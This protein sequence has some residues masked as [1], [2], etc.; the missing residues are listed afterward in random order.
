MQEPAPEHRSRIIVRLVQAVQRTARE[1]ALTIFPAVVISLL[2]NVYVAGATIVDGPSMQPNLYTDYRVMTERV[3]YHLHPPRRG[4]V[5]VVERPDGEIPLVKRVLA[6]PGEIVEVRGGH[7][8]INHTPIREPW[9]TYW[10]GQDYPPTVVPVGHVFVLGDN[11]AVS[12]DSREIGPVPLDEVQRHVV[13]IF[14]P[15]DQI[16]LLP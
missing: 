4:D 15:L 11:R 1:L 7:V 9:V 16:K 13:F 14:W 5:V 12:R 8:Y 6:L 3:S 10:G 2:I